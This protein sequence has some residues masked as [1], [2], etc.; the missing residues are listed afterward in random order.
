MLDIDNK[1]KGS[2]REVF[3]TF[4]VLGLTSF[5]GPVAHLG[6]FRRALVQQ[7][8]WV[9]ES[10]YT[11]LLALCQFLPG[12]ASSQLGFALG[13]LRAGWMGAIAAF[14]GFTLPSAL[15]LVG[16][17]AALPYLSSAQGELAVH[18]LKL[19]AC[20]VVADA[21]LGMSKNLLSDTKTR[22]L[23]LI[24]CGLLLVLDGALYQLLVVGGAA[25]VGI[26][27]GN[28]GQVQPLTLAPGYS[29]RLGLFWLGVFFACFVAL[30]L[31][32]QFGGLWV[33]AEAFYRAGALV[34]GGG[35]VVLPLLEASVVGQGWVS[36]DAF[37]A[38]YGASQA[39]PGPMFA[40]AAYL[41]AL[42]ETGVGALWGASVA[43]ISLFLPG[44]LLVSAAL[45]LWQKINA[46]A[47][48]RRAVMGVNAAVVGVLASALYDPVFTSAVNDGVDLA[49][50]LLAFGILR[51]WQ[52]SPL[53]AVLACVFA[54]FLFV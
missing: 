48:A 41:G 16:A 8:A 13:L 24:A 54:S 6:Y 51:I 38:G 42:S 30:L 39:I 47:S 49:I 11:Q 27:I 15:L 45:P 22:A 46:Y 12:P 18:G 37:L 9:N 3:L 29:A 43:L 23:A 34:F 31:G 35:H 14:V 21:V 53:W 28:T 44:F 4:P 52:L 5:G 25:I 26:L 20:A 2:A 40:F 1:N 50:V 7:R 19:L 32:T 10:Q 17:A 36:E 33:L